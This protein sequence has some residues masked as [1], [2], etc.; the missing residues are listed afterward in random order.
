[1]KPAH[2]LAILLFAMPLASQTLPESSKPQP[3]R[4]DWA[5]LASAAAARGTDTYSTRKML[6]HGNHEMFLP[7]FVVNHL[8]VLVAFESGI[9]TLNYFAARNLVRHH[10]RKLARVL[11]L[12]DQLQVYPWAIHNLTLHTRRKMAVLGPE[13]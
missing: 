7:A 10:H 8:P 6:C 3:D 9:V 11:I 13:K 5:L 12:S 4:I 2:L 1:M